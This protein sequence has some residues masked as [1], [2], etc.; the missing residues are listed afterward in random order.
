M[1]LRKSSQVKRTWEDDKMETVEL[2]HHEFEQLP[3]E[4]EVEKM[5]TV[6]MSEPIKD[7]ETELEEKEKKKRKVKRKKT[8]KPESDQP[9]QEDEDVPMD[10]EERMSPPKDT[11]E[12]IDKEETESEKVG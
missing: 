5:T 8:S 10:E 1:K 2:K 11:P 6:V 4:E 7:K 3:L 9:A 12:P